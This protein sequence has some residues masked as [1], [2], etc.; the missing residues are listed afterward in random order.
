MKK[1][2]RRKRNGDEIIFNMEPSIMDGSILEKD[3]F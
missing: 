3:Y 2:K 1:K